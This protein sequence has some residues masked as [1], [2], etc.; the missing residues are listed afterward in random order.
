[1]E[2]VKPHIA[3]TTSHQ[4]GIDFHKL[5][6]IV[7]SNLWWLL[8][9]FVAI[10][11]AAYIM[12]RYTKDL[13]ESS[14][15]IKLDIKNEATALGIETFVADDPL[16]TDPISGEIELIRAK[17]FLNQVLDSLNLDVSYFSKGEV[18]NHELF[19]ATPIQVDYNPKR[20]TA[21]NQ[22]IFF[23][24]INDD[25]FYLHVG[26]EGN[27]VK[28]TYDTP[29]R[30]TNFEL[31]LTKN[32]S[33]ST[34]DEIDLFF[35]IN[36]R[37]VLLNYITA[38][39]IVEPLNYSAK[40]IRVAFKD[41]QPAKA[42][43]IVHTVDAMYLR[44]SHQQKNLTNT[45]KIDWLNKELQ[46]IEMKM[47]GFEDYFKK[48]TLQ[49]KTNNLDQDLAKT[50][51]S[52]NT[53][54]SQ[55][56]DLTT[57][58]RDINRLLDG[59]QTHEIFLSPTLKQALPDY[60]YENLDHIQ[61]LTQEM[62]R[63]KLSYNEVTFAYREQQQQIDTRTRKASQQL[64]E[65]KN[66]WVIRLQELN[67]RKS[68]LENEFANLPDKST[69]FSKNQRFY[70]L[71]E[72]F[73]LSLMQS[74]AGFEIAQAG[75]T[76]D[77]KILSPAS[78]PTTPISP[79]RAMIAGIGLVASLMLILFVIG[80]LYLV[81]NKIT[82]Q[83]ELEKL[84]GV[85]V[86]GVIPASRHTGIQNLHVVNY[87]KSVVSEAIRTLRTNLDFFRTESPQRVVALSSTISGEGKSF[88]A[89]NLGGAIAISRK[90]VVLIDLDM[91]KAKANLPIEIPDPSKGMSTVLIRKDRWQDCVLHTN[92]EYFDYIPS[93]PIPPNPSE[94]LLNGE[95]SSIL[96]DLKKH[97]DIIL[98]DTPPVGLVTDG[99]QAMKKADMSI[100][101]FRADY[102]KRDFIKNLQRII[103]I[104]HITNVT[105][106]LNALPMLGENTNG[107]GYYE[108]ESDSKMEMIRTLF[109]R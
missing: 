52:I 92:L 27:K 70:K 105:T 47:E 109:K 108:D 77:F 59:I 9:I 50:I 78:L 57:R 7:L 37:D 67:R 17:L 48:F 20:T 12:I 85:P 64:Q 25:E 58:I 13:Y 68:S 24:K 82:A 84:P 100:Y 55:R 56:Y 18:L 91:R 51:Q 96:E 28:G 8:L 45:Q 6:V 26:E 104:N 14:S 33:F 76:P 98:L 89:L 99:I 23:E 83:H 65:M 15:E 39:L 41:N 44:Y 22:Q 63:M 3:P 75:T 2:P 61:D 80:V 31:V 35:V 30:S 32:T 66:Q 16:A 72:E 107:Y 1:M 88:V 11:A 49:N 97:Y 29:V 81:N 74:K 93:G 102:S 53:V 19:T 21:Y 36:S 86:L 46:Q 73:Y 71:Y 103:T 42:Q 87:P 79:N 5:R 4:E 10:N 95:F 62:E 54:D 69:Q 38:N 34:T 60:L 94:L 101:I 106:L 43:A 90:K 40:T